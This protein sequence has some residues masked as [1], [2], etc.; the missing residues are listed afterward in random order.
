[1]ILE[2]LIVADFAT[3]WVPDVHEQRTLLRLFAL[4]NTVHAWD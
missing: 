1:M 2:G 4:P 3:E